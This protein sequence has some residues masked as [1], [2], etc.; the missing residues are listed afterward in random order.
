MVRAPSICRRAQG[1][2]TTDPK[3]GSHKLRMLSRNAEQLLNTLKTTFPGS[4]FDSITSCA[5]GATSEI[6]GAQCAWARVQRLLSV[7]AE[8]EELYSTVGPAM[9]Q[10]LR[11]AQ[12][13]MSRTASNYDVSRL[14]L[15]LLITGIA[16]LLVFPATYKECSRHRSSG[17]FLMLMVII[18]GVMMFAS[19]YVEEE[20][21]FWYWICSGWIFFLHIKSV[22]SAKL[23]PSKRFGSLASWSIILLAISQR[24]LRRWNQTG[25]KFA[26]EPDIARTFFARHPNIF[27]VLLILTYLDAGRY[28]VRSIPVS[29]IMRLGALVPVVLAFTFKLHFVASESPELFDETFI[30]PVVKK[31]PYSLSLVLHARLV[32]YGLAVIV[33]LALS[34]G[35]RSRVARGELTHASILSLSWGNPILIR[36]SSTE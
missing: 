25:Q 26:A 36:I 7:R 27:W 32:F 35:I 5:S 34:I 12:E 21:Q 19:S 23:I 14:V 15:G 13:V 9:L 18:Y 3:A 11:I 31:W 20:Q 33:L 8:P 1:N 30:A 24:L 29:G 6:E 28:L 16:G 10:F 22:S 4:T 17:L 2:L